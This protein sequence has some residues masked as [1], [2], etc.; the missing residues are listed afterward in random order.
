MKSP[1]PLIYLYL[2]VPHYLPVKIFFS[3][4]YLQVPWLPV[5]VDFPRL[6][7]SASV[8]CISLLPAPLPQATGGQGCSQQGGRQQSGEWTLDTE[9][10]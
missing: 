10:V 9:T 5:P 7:V 2:E 4:L 1:L 3:Y 6:P 8:T